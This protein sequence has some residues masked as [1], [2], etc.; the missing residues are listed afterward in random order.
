MLIVIQ[1]IIG[2]FFAFLGISSLVGTKK[3]LENFQHLKLPKVV[4]N[5]N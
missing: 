1:I 2:L 5:I 3:A 4:S